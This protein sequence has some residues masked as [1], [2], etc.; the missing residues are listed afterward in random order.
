MGIVKLFGVS[1]ICYLLH[2]YARLLKR[3]K[4]NTCTHKNI[5]DLH[6]TA[7]LPISDKGGKNVGGPK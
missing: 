1:I 2:E 4:Q 5:K 7:S 3:K 6:N